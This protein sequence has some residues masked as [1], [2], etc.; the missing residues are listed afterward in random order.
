MQKRQ[1]L[2]LHRCRPDILPERAFSA[3][4]AEMAGVNARWLKLHRCQAINKMSL[5]DIAVLIL[6][7]ISVDT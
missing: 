2:N 3:V 4:G 1:V 5:Y 7:L 6:L